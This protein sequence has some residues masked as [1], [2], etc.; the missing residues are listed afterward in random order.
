MCYFCSA[1][2]LT[3][4]LY[5]REKRA[6]EETGE[7]SEKK[8]PEDSSSATHTDQLGIGSVI[9][10]LHISLGKIGNL[11]LINIRLNSLISK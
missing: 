7:K 9:L 3:V 2:R 6:S 10:H 1:P 4:V 8:E 11:I 5:F